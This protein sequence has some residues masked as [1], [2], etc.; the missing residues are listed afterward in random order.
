MLHIL[1]KPITV[2]DAPLSAPFSLQISH[3]V[4]YIMVIFGLTVHRQSWRQCCSYL[5]FQLHHCFSP[6]G[7]LQALLKED[8]FWFP[9]HFLATHA[10]CWSH[11]ESVPNTP[12]LTVQLGWWNYGFHKFL[13]PP[14]SHS[15]CIYL[16]R[17]GKVIRGNRSQDASPT[18][19]SWQKVWAQHGWIPQLSHTLWKLCSTSL[20]PTG[21]SD[22]GDHLQ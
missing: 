11:G 10:G 5:P 4:L 15:G 16:S 17:P 6:G 9:I 3:T 22:H 1:W 7:K 2:R 12:L 18:S 21:H 20:V 13:H 14:F 19:G 8:S